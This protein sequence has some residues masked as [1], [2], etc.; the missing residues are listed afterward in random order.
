VA[1][2]DRKKRNVAQLDDLVEI[3]GKELENPQNPELATFR[4][5][6]LLEYSMHWFLAKRLGVLESDLPNLDY[7]DLTT[8]A[9]PG[10]KFES[11]RVRTLKLGEV[12]NYLGHYLDT[13]VWLSKVREFVEMMGLQVPSRDDV[14]LHVHELAMYDLYIETMLRIN[15]ELAGEALNKADQEKLKTVRAQQKALINQA[16]SMIK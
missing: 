8:L 7:A 14:L 16:L 13:R 3:V 11:L 12:R 6:I 10:A 9:L 4:I 5:P 2:V 15:A 1:K